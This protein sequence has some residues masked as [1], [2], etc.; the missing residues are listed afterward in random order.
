VLVS[1]LRTM[2]VVCWVN[3]FC[4]VLEPRGR[5]GGKVGSA[6]EQFEDNEG[7]MLG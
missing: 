5:L 2:R 7:G 1:N 6:C 3:V 4:L